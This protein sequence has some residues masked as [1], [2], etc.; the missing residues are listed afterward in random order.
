MSEWMSQRQ[1]R[2]AKA[3]RVRLWT[4]GAIII[5]VL[6]IQSSIHSCTPTVPSTSVFDVWAM[7]QEAERRAGR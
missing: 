1:I 5:A 4:T 6:L 2:E 7:Q 3:A